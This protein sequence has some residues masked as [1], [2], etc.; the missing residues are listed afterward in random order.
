[1]DEY[2]DVIIFDLG[3]S[4]IQLNDLDRGFSFSSNKRLN[5]TM[6][7]NKFSALEVINKLS[8]KELREKSLSWSPNRSAAALMLWDYYASVKNRKG[9]F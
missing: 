8:E 9:I 7:L 4:S 5:M 2:V 6:G 3:L 1:M